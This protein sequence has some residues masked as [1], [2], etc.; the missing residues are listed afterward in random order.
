MAEVPLTTAQSQATA[1]ARAAPPE[2]RLEVRTGAGPATTYAVGEAGL[3]IGAVPGCDLRLPGPDLPPLLC[4]IARQGGA[5]TLRKLAPTFPVL[6]NGKPATVSPLT[7][8]DRVSAGPVEIVVH[9]EA[10]STQAAPGRPFRA[11]HFHP[12]PQPIDDGGREELRQQVLLF[13]EEVGRFRAQR[14]RIEEEQD[15]R[16][17]ELERREQPVIRQADELRQQQAAL[18]KRA[19]ALDTQRQELAAAKQE[20]ADIRRELYDRYRERRDRLTGLQDAINR[21]ARKVQERK[22][23][24]EEDA[25]QAQARREEEASRHAELDARAAELQAQRDQLNEERVLLSRQREEMHRE[26]AERLAEGQARADRVDAERAALERDQAQLRED[27]VLLERRRDELERREAEAAQKVKEHEDKLEQL[28]RDTRDLEEQVLQLDEWHTKLC[29]VGERLAKQKAEQDAQA[30]QLAARAAALEGQQATLA[31]LRTRLERLREEVRQEEQEL[32]DQRARQEAAEAEVKQRL[33]EAKQALAEMEAEKA[34]H[35]QERQQYVERTALMEAAVSQMRQAQERLAQQEAELNQRA[36]DLEAEATKQAE[37]TSLTQARLA[38]LE[39]LQKRLEAEREG[40]R[41]RTLLLSQAEQARESLQEQL[42]RRSEELLA[43]QKALAEQTAQHEAAARELEA[44]RANLEQERHQG[45]EALAGLRDE[46]ERRG[47][48][49]QQREAELAAREENLK[50]QRE[51]VQETGRAVAAQRKTLFADRAAA[52][53]AKDQAEL[54]AARVRA[55]FDAIR[56]DAVA[57]Q[58]LLPELELRAGTALERLTHAREQLREHLGEVHT[59]ARQCEDDLEALKGQVQAGAERL[60]QQETALRRGQDEHRLAV[61]AFRQQ[62]IE[63]Q[64]QV[65]ETKRLLAQG[66]TRLQRRRAEVDEQARRVQAD[67]ERLARQ[68]EH[69][70]AEERAVAERRGEV[71]RHLDDM[72]DWY[73]RKLRELAGVRTPPPAPAEAGVT[74]GPDEAAPAP[75][76]GRD[77]LSLTGDVEPADRQLGDLL[78]SLGLVEADTLTALL[79]EARRQRRSLRQVL[80]AGGVVT[81]YQMALIE[82]GN[83][84]ALVLGRLRVV[85]RLRTTPQETVYRVF[86]P[87]RGHEVVLRHLAEVE[88]DDAV[89]PDE[90]RQRF[91]QAALAHPNL[92]AT[93]EVLEIAGRPAALQEWLTGVPSSEWPP[94]AAAPGV[95][96]RLLLQA[97][98]GLEAAHQAGLVHG[99]LT[100]A[101]VLL[102]GEGIVKLCGFGE[103]SWLAVPPFAE[104]AEG[105]AADLLALGQ[106]AAGWC[107]AGRRKGKGKALPDALQA[108][109][110]RLTAEAPEARYASASDLLE[111]LDRARDAV[112]ANPEAWDRLL[113][114]VR[115]EASPLA[116]YRQTA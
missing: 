79:V 101:L 18:E 106:V 51:R 4:V 57:L 10:T 35:E 84:D 107:A 26:L 102:S 8:G 116:T 114:Q 17:R 19:A 62:L 21:A 12:V 64:G 100:P 87:E 39:D 95:W 41:E 98:Q 16:A 90:F 91:A 115:D 50:R 54:E 24:V 60:Q 80:L 34:L 77:I 14:Q 63:W 47:A 78:R 61:A 5:A 85:D 44:R 99:H 96:Y 22:Q 108:I 43:R 70:Q 59:F 92:A 105:A 89:R 2:V 82:A 33:E 30:H 69:L 109:L 56:R 48:E 23:Q 15:Q 29:A 112:P 32:A 45:E 46:I 20:L 42:R 36:A 97:A 7:Q 13:R 27:L 52:E 81:L 72:R 103:P 11:P 25:R 1:A 93:L 83:L 74:P 110:D 40:L 104:G 38:Q 67:S 71:D 9:I 73:C 65:A 86:D 94:L 76:G 66:E 31:T 55:D 3:L 37:Q 75:P 58:Q 6:V 28:Q 49:Q 88:A 113:R 111:E 53:S 68:A